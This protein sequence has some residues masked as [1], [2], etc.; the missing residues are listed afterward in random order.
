MLKRID[1]EIQSIKDKN[2]EREN[3]IEKQKA[4]IE[5]RIK[6]PKKCLLRSI[7]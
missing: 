7:L 3:G 2:I 6:M 1:N 4:E 5:E